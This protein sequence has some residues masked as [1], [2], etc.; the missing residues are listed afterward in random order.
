MTEAEGQHLR[1]MYD[2]KTLQLMPSDPSTQETNDIG[3]RFLALD[4]LR[5][6]LD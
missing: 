4:R 2:P 3:H 5:D 6:P 1:F